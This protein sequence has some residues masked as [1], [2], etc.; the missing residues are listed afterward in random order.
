MR[1]PPQAGPA[2]RL[3]SVADRDKIR[4]LTTKALDDFEGKPVGDYGPNRW[5]YNFVSRWPNEV[6]PDARGEALRR[7]IHR[8]VILLG[9][10]VDC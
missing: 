8:P 2:S 3:K 5:T 9:W 4:A 6:Y 10:R 7:C 1:L